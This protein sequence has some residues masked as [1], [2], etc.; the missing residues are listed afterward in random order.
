V[1]EGRVLAADVLGLE[2]AE[3]LSGETFSIK[4]ENG[5]VYLNDIVMVIITDIFTSNGVIHVINTVLVP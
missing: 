1:V 2:E 3:T 4:I 5:N